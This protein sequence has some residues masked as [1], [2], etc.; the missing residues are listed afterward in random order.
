MD[1]GQSTKNKFSFFKEEIV[2]MSLLSKVAL[3]ISICRLF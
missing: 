2:L 1:G 3:P